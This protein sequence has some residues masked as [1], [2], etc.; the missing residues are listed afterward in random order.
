[1]YYSSKVGAGAVL[2]Q[3]LVVIAV[4]VNSKYISDAL[5]EGIKSKVVC[6]DTVF[7]PSSKK[8]KAYTAFV[9]GKWQSNSTRIK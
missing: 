3:S 5:L 2:T 6:I 4:L 1:M 9:V 8:Y 7:L